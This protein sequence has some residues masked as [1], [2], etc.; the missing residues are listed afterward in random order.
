M[1]VRLGLDVGIEVPRDDVFEVRF[2]VRL[3]VVGF[4]KRGLRVKSLV[5]IEGELYLT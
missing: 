1:V 5:N 3:I 2:W 4:V